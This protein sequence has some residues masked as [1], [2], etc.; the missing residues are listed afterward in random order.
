MYL[1]QTRPRHKPPP[2]EG[3]GQ[4]AAPTDRRSMWEEEELF[5]LAEEEELFA[6]AA[7]TLSPSPS[8]CLFS[9]CLFS[10]CLFSLCLSLCRSLS[11]SLS[12]FLIRWR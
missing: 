10:L 12:L 2:W 3:S 11:L 7:L 1:N 6:L 4:E 8:L 9:L 5:A